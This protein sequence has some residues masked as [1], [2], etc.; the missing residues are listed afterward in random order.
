[1]VVLP[2]H[3]GLGGAHQLL[4][5]TA[6]RGLVAVTSDPEDDA[7]ACCFN[8]G[9]KVSPSSTEKNSSRAVAVSGA[10][11]ACVTDKCP[12]RALRCASTVLS[13]VSEDLVPFLM[14]LCHI[15]RPKKMLTHMSKP[16]SPLLF[17][18]WYPIGHSGTIG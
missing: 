4:C 17:A 7:T 11:E 5:D 6:E 9:H 3:T 10:V 18:D 2:T 8:L 16:L 12:A 1:M 13:K 14:E 15:L